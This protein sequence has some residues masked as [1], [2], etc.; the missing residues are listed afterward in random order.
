[1]GKKKGRKAVY[2]GSFDPVTNG[3]LWVIEQGSEMFDELVVGIGTNPDKEY[4]FTL[5]ERV[6]LLEQISKDLPNV[7]VDTFEHKLAVTYAQEV[8]AEYILR[9]VRSESDYEYER[10]MRH[11][12]SDVGPEILTVFIMSPRE[13]AEISS[14]LV[15][16]LIG[17][18]GW[19]EIVKMYV[20]EPVYEKFIE[21]FGDAEE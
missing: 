10:G 12:N 11:V 20:P 18:E 21:K 16:G 9:G 17:F 14:S 1:M 6:E 19:E 4:T 3:H 15:T 13:S 5:D 7:S 8:G 2:I